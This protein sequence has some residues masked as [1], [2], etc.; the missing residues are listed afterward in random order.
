MNW[1]PQ[2]ETRTKFLLAPQLANLFNECIKSGT[3]PDILKVAK[4]IP[5]HKGGSK[6]DLF[7]QL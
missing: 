3:Y 5:L 1:T 4:V 2:S 7:K 6:F